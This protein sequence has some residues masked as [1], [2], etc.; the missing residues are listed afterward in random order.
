MITKTVGPAAFVALIAALVM[1]ILPWAEVYVTAPGGARPI[2]SL[3]VVVLVSALIPVVVGGLARRR[4]PWS[5]GVSLITY[6][7]VIA[8][9]GVRPALSLS[10]VAD[11][12]GA[13]L[14]RLL[15]STPPLIVDAGTLVPALTAGWIAGAVAGELFVRTRQI[16]G[17]LVPPVA[18]LMA[19][20]AVTAREVFER[21]G[22]V[23]QVAFGLVLFALLCAVVVARRLA[24]EVSERGQPSR[25]EQRKMAEAPLFAAALVA[26]ASFVVLVATNS[27]PGLRT[28]S[29]ALSL[30][31]A[32][33]VDEPVPDSPVR[34]LRNLRE[35][36]AS[37]RQADDV[38]FRV[39]VDGDAPGY[40]AVATFDSYNGAYWDFPRRFDPTGFVV[41]GDADCGDSV[42]QRYEVVEPIGP[43]PNVLVA[44]SDVVCA[45]PMEVVTAG[46]ASEEQVLFDPASKMLWSPV[47]LGPGSRYEVF[48]TPVAETLDEL[49]ASDVELF[50]LQAG[51]PSGAL[52][53]SLARSRDEQELASRIAR[54]WLDEIAKVEEGEGGQ[55]DESER[56]SGQAETIE[57]LV[58]ALNWMRKNF[59][60]AEL[61]ADDDGVSVSLTVL[62]QQLRGPDGAGD[63][64]VEQLT[65]LYALIVSELGVDARLV[66]GFRIDPADTG[67]TTSGLVDLSAGDA[68]T[69]VEVFVGDRG[70]VVADIEPD[71]TAE[72]ESQTD[73]DTVGGGEDTSS[74]QRFQQLRIPGQQLPD[75]L[76]GSP[77]T[78]WGLIA[79]LVVVIP[80]AGWLL[81]R[82]ARRR[83][84][85]RKGDPL[86]LSIGAWHETLDVLSEAHVGDL[87]ALTSTEVVGMSS[88]QFGDDVATSVAG[89]ATIADPAVFSCSE[90][91]AEQAAAAWAAADRTRRDLK[92]SLTVRQRAMALGR[93]A[94]RHRK[95][96][97]PSR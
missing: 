69:W 82:R 42:L 78:P 91:T 75:D 47:P 14:S 56:F 18:L 46:G 24:I 28:D 44:L 13:A 2:A 81:T 64:S 15:S 34:V 3:V 96:A 65:T 33:Q 63:G 37:G 30:N 11:G 88:Q 74:Q 66:T 68:W 86:A 83:A 55:G 67:G 8:T 79:G 87:E 1:A 70:W 80:A 77:S 52:R 23:S 6:A 89:V 97:A 29:D 48:S 73:V 5:L 85:R 59:S 12:Y 39:E 43:A 76:D 21:G 71:D 95:K 62:D 41:S 16:G 36:A 50:G 27:V 49:E 57:P 54:S 26:L 93:A 72:L 45:P 35:D 40:F 60:L 10:A 38:L 94:F 22:V 4:F 84:K 90:I 58:E 20:L 19:S 17:L 32:P 7:A 31:L 61:D 25:T 53:Q 9:V 51:P 92:R